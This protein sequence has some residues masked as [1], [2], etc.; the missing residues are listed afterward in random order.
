MHIV[1]FVHNDAVFY[2]PEKNVNIFCYY[3]SCSVPAF[4]DLSEETLSAIADVLEE[5]G[6]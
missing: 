5:V 1:I 2:G 3:F 4:K 6:V